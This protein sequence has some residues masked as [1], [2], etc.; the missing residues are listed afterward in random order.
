MTHLA[1][2]LFFSLVFIGA[3]IAAQ[4]LVKE[5]WEEIVAALRGRPQVRKPAVS[6][7]KVKLR[8]GPRYAPALPRR[9]AF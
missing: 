3:G 4:L 6:R 7:F 9:A 1:T 8:P 5:Y 2:A